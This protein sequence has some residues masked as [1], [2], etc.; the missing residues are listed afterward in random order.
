MKIA[1]L[2]DW[3]SPL[4]GYSDNFLPKA[5]ASLGH[6]VHL[7]ASNAQVY[8][9][10]PGYKDIFEKFLGPGLV[11]CGTQKV[12]GYTLHRLPCS[13]M[14]NRIR[15]VGLQGKLNEIRPDIVQAGEIYSLLVYQA[16]LRKPVLGFKF[17]SECH[18]HASV[19]PMTQEKVAL[20]NRIRWPIYA[21][22]VGPLVS[23]MTEKCYAIS[24]DAGEIAE[25]Y[26][27]I[28]AAKV[29]V[30]SLGVDT[31]LFHPLGHDQ[32]DWRRSVRS[33]LGIPEDDVLCVY[34]GRL[35]P[36]KGPLVL[37]QAIGKLRQ[38]GH[39]VHGLFVGFGAQSYMAEIASYPG[40]TLKEFVPVQ[41]LSKYY[42][43][44]DI[45]VWPKQESTSQLDALSCG[46][47]LILSNRIQ[48]LERVDGCGLLYE[49]DSSDD[50]AA[51]IEM[52]LD[53]A[54]RRQLGSVGSKKIKENYSWSG[55][56]KEYEKDYQR[57]LAR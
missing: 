47:P 1:L 44:S 24:T 51:K 3:H 38:Q 25:R 34:T 32:A 7:I 54:R 17:F 15:I 35:A 11:E 36:E 49:E 39:K 29:V 52:L 53:P 30:R 21:R 45:G 2:V 43:I 50:L 41:A 48:V 5:L 4:M 19:F 12:D 56:A 26:F 37:A 42:Q 55:L 16:L 31:E 28:A 13:L 23:A 33:E 9:N 20:R 46:L 10:Y 18:V 27:G 8:F 57:S 22:T 40:V 6:E 14:W